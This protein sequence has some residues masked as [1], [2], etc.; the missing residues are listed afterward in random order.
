MCARSQTSGL[1]SAECAVSTSASESGATSASVRSRASARA[2]AAAAACRACVTAI[3][4]NATESGAPASDSAARAPGAPP[5]LDDLADRGRALG[6]ARVQRP[7]ARARSA[8]S[9]A[10]R[11]RSPARGSGGPSCRRA[12]CPRRRCPWRSPPRRLGGAGRRR[13]LEQR[14]LR[15]GHASRKLGRVPDGRRR[16]PPTAPGAGATLAS[17][18]VRTA[19]IDVRSAASA[20]S[21]APRNA[22]EVLGA[23]ESAAVQRGGVGEVEPVRGGDVAARSRRACSR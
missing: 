18:S 19:T 9:R 20:R 15:L 7:H 11:A 12:R 3:S 13:D 4:A 17:R 6:D 14:G 23:L 16:P 22:V 1:I 2:A 8:R 5:H 10:A 21:S